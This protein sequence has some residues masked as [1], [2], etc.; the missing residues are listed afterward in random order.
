MKDGS[1]VNGI[2]GPERDQQNTSQSAPGTEMI[3]F[4]M[5]AHVCVV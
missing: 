5:V 3:T 4:K 2:S 1:L